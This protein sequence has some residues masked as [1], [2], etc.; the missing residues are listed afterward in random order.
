MCSTL[1]LFIFS[2]AVSSLSR[3]LTKLQCISD[4]LE[5][6]KATAEKANMAKTN[7]LARVSHEL[8]T[9]LHA[10]LGMLE[11]VEQSKLLSIVRKTSVAFRSAKVAFSHSFAERKATI[12]DRKLL[13]DQRA[14]IRLANE[15]S[16]SLLTLAN[17][18][19][20]TH[21][22]LKIAMPLRIKEVSVAVEKGCSGGV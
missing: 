16:T 18:L 3:S 21:T 5:K 20:S 8:R 22:K 9:P 2:P 12:K 13:S 15:A 7:F 11:L 10:I 14:K 17:D 19:T 6:A 4:E 1:G